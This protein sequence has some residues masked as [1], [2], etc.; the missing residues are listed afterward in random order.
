[1]HALNTPTQV[2]AE[3][4]ARH[5]VDPADIEAV[6]QWFLEDLPKLPTAQI[7][8]ILEELMASHGTGDVSIETRCYPKSAPLPSLDASPPA[9][10]PL[11]AARWGQ[12][13]RLLLARLPRNRGK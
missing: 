5:G 11:L 4:A 3:V 6:Q 13:L 1:L 9:Q 7:E 8:E 12:I 2:F 10:T